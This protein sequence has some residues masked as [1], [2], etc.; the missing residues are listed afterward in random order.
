MKIAV[1]RER[2]F[3]ETRVSATPESVKKLKIG[4]AHV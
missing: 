2:R 3:N 4:R 1:L